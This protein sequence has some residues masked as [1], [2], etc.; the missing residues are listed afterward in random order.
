MAFWSQGLLGFI[1]FRALRFKGSALGVDPVFQS[2][3][4]EIL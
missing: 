1:G 4:E 3:S 2:P